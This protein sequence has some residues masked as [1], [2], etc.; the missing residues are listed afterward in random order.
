[1][2]F[3]KHLERQQYKKWEDHYMAYRE[4]NHQLKLCLLASNNSPN[5]NNTESSANNNNNNVGLT[6]RG[7]MHFI[8]D[9]NSSGG[10]TPGG[11]FSPERES[12][13]DGL[14]PTRKNNRRF[15]D[16]LPSI[17]GRT[18]SSAPQKQP[19][20]IA[21]I[22]EESPVSSGESYTPSPP[23]MNVEE[24]EEDEIEFDLEANNNNN[25][26]DFDSD[27]PSEQ[28]DKSMFVSFFR[29]LFFIDI[30]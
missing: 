8:S 9:G 2:K 4:L 7:N 23:I 3:G 5:N 29:I 17:F 18:S 10:G 30:Y 13:P 12:S 14:L 11:S 26:F 15:T 22:G 24:E 16:I 21:M 20:A 25:V 19:S 1:M 27:T 28:Q 6:A